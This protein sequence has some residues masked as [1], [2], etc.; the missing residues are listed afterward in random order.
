M[1]QALAG[2][3][4]N[5]ATNYKDQMLQAAIMRI[6]P[7]DRVTPCRNGICCWRWA[8][9]HLLDECA[10]ARASAHQ[11]REAFEEEL[12]DSVLQ[13]LL[14]LEKSYEQLEKKLHTT[15]EDAEK[16]R[17]KNA[18][19][20]KKLKEAQEQCNQALVA[21]D[22]ALSAQERLEKELNDMIALYKEQEAELLQMS[23]PREQLALMERQVEELEINARD[24]LAAKEIAEKEL[25]TQSTI[26]SE[27]AMKVKQLE[28][29]ENQHLKHRQKARREGKSGKSQKASKA[30]D[31]RNYSHA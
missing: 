1:T 23:A 3:V 13:Q 2:T 16:E 10:T 4:I 20:E 7:N 11:L 24:A 5:E 18:A 17:R 19:S 8:A 15:M 26:A 31:G 30:I 9:R 29:F 14:D 21:R 12:G 25:R 22:R 27:L 6:A 28:V